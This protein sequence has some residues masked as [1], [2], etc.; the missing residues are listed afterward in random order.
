MGPEQKARERAGVTCV[1]SSIRFATTAR[2]AGHGLESSPLSAGASEASKLKR[3]VCPENFEGQVRKALAA[4]ERV[5]IAA[6]GDGTVNLL[7]NALLNSG[8]R[9]EDVVIG[10]VGLGSSN[11]FHKP[12][13]PEAF[14]EGVPVRMDW[15]NA[16]ACD[17][18][19][20]RY[21]NGGDAL[22][23]RY[24]LIN[25]SI[26]VTAEANALYNSRARF[27]ALV[28]SISHEAAV[29]ASALQTIVCYQNI[30]AELSLERRPA[31]TFKITN[32]GV[33]KNPHFAG[34]LCYDTAIRPDDGRFGINLCA[35]M[36]K[37]EA[38]KTL[39]PFISK[40]L[41]RASQNVFLVRPR[42]RPGEPGAVRPGDG[43]RS[44]QNGQ[45]LFPCLSR[46]HKVLRMSILEEILE[47]KAINAWARHFARSRFQVNKPHESDAELIETEDSSHL[48]A[49]TIDTISEEI[50]QGVY[51]DPFTMGWVTVMSN[52][53]D[54]AAV[55]AE[56]LGIVISVALEPRQADSF[57]DGIARGMAA[58]CQALGVFILGG[59]TSTAR[60]LSLTGCAFGFVPRGEKLMRIG[61]RPGDVVFLSGGA[62]R[63]NALGLRALARNARAI[64]PRALL[65]ACG[66]PQGRETDPKI[67]HLLHGHERRTV[68][69][70]RPAR[71]AQSIGFSIEADW[72][73][74]LAPDV[75]SILR[76]RRNSALVHG[77]GYSR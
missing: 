7:L 47:N 71:P 44:G 17:V 30:A 1:S 53:S 76:P 64:F 43:R 61:G 77:R 8:A 65:Q 54:L 19:A 10:A 72:R 14:I 2:A 50:S 32:L 75:L 3:S 41:Q 37:W 73:K 34:G 66:A 16:S 4:G 60:E 21:Q 20:V 51:R 74:I 39:A 35:G 58:A 24:C 33:I 48:L 59:D 46:T 31:R 13:R 28:Q 68:H 49:V 67:R 23:T 42:V 40:G 45:G 38:V 63:G 26:G 52:F 69:H 6:G 56:A 70:A 22:S 9:R 12:F 18:I 5:F 27:I 62:G 55:G 11:D 25:A 36:T 15:Q 57:R 29:V